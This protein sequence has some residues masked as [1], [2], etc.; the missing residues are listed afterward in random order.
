MDAGGD[1]WERRYLLPAEHVPVLADAD[2]VLFG[3]RTAVQLA[4]YGRRLPDVVRAYRTGEAPP[5]LPWEPEGRVD[6]NRALFQQ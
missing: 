2:S 4:R 3:A 5:P 1:A 6:T